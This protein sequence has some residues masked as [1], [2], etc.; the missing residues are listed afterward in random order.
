M[1][2]LWLKIKKI[3]AVKNLRRFEK[4]AGWR[5]L[6]F[7]VLR[8]N[9]AGKKW[10]VGSELVCRRVRCQPGESISEWRYSAQ[11]FFLARTTVLP[12]PQLI[13]N[14]PLWS[15]AEDSETAGKHDQPSWSRPQQSIFRVKL[16]KNQRHRVN[17][18][19]HGGSASI[20][21]ERDSFHLRNWLRNWISCL[22]LIEHPQNH[23]AKSLQRFCQSGRPLLQPVRWTFRKGHPQT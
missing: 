2:N 5:V 23:G 22:R 6:L 19:R 16:V 9:R 3:C 7:Q 18:A 17:T 14:C 12:D 10:T 15:G 13:L 4:R 20:A 11:D 8:E 21:G 1:H